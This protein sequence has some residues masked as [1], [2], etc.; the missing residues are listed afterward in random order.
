MRARSSRKGVFC[1]FS[2]PPVFVLEGDG[3]YLGNSWM[4]ESIPSGKCAYFLI[5]MGEKWI[6]L[7]LVNIFLSN[8]N[9]IRAMKWF[10]ETWKSS[11]MI[12]RLLGFNMNQYG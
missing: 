3:E 8:F 6:S 2:Q 9:D 1:R 4:H 12:L 7:H 11:F 5:N 10:K